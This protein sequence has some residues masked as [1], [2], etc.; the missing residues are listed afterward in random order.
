MPTRRVW[1]PKP[2]KDEKR[3]LGITPMYDRTLQNV[4]KAALEPE[5]EALF[6]PN[7]YGFPP[8]RSAHDAIWQVKTIIRQK[9]KYVLDADLARCFDGINHEALQKLK[10]K[11]KVR[12]QIKAW[13]K[14]RVIDQGAFTATSLGTMPGGVISPLLA[15]IAR[16][17]LEE[18]IAE[19]FPDNGGYIKATKGYGRKKVSVPK[20][21]RYLAEDF[22]VV[23]AEKS[24]VQRCGE[25]I[26]EWLNR[27]KLEL[28][29]EK[30]RLTHNGP[31]LSEDGQAG[32]DFLGEHF[33]Q[34]PAGKYRSDRDS[35][36]RILGFDTC[37]TP[38][39]KAS[40]AHQEK[41]RIAKHNSSPQAALIKDLNPVRQGWCNYYFNCDAR[42]EFK[43]LDFLTYLKLRGWAKRRCKNIFDGHKKY[44]RTI[45]SDNWVFATR[46]GEA[47]PLGLI[48]HNSTSSSSTKYVKVK[49]DKS[50]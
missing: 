6:E 7:S 36:N 28:K 26:S 2:G 43:N 10:I 13:L 35:K 42:E 9:A 40:K 19:A 18:S 4:V 22:V 16:H 34:F 17:G 46:S 14:S 3:P 20:I 49:G 30:T 25:I 21:V 11:G 39:A 8:G 50:P 5:W 37:V 23:C 24:V 48:K 38:S 27:V 31:K 41:I 12:Q 15:N 47:N 29:P 1:I 33:Q 32:F 44:W 45:G